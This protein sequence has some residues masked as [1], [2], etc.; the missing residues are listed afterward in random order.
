MAVNTFIEIP[1][2]VPRAED[3]LDF[4]FEFYN[5]IGMQS[6]ITLVTESVDFRGSNLYISGNDNQLSGSVIVGNGIIF[7]GF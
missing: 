3:I 5:E 4:K 7:E 1:I 2:D 6:N